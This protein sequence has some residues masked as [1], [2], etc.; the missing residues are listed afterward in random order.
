[1][2]AGDSARRL[3]AAALRHHLAWYHGYRLVGPPGLHRGLPSPYLTLIITLGEPLVLAA[4]PDPR[5]AGGSYDS[6]VGG[7]HDRPATIVHPGRQSG[8]QIALHP[9]GV[10]DLLGVPAG[11][12]AR[13][14]VELSDV[15]GAWARRL[16]EQVVEQPTWAGRFDVLDAA[17]TARL[18]A[19][20]GRRPASAAPA[21]ELHRA[22]HL[23]VR[24]CAPPDVVSRAR[25]APERVSPGPASPEPVGALAADL[26]WSPRRLLERFRGELGVGPKEAARI[27]RFDR[28]RRDLFH[29]AALGGPL[30]LAELA[31]VH[32]YYDQAHLAREFRAL[33]G[34]SPSRLVAEELRFV[35]AELPGAGAE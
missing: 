15:A 12:L 35:Q 8:I 28:A 3:P 14:D 30:R 16:R 1:V 23:L 9:L 21:P 7:L 4:H 19:A 32:G 5:Q 26:G 27:A 18:S 2:A 10:R 24:H 13:L 34:C 22:W 29:R 6:L 11:E 25:S 17:L 20:D 33:A 31:V